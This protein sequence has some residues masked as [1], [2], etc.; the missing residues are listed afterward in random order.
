[1]SAAASS[2]SIPTKSTLSK[3]DDGAV[4][5]DKKVM[6]LLKFPKF[7]KT[8]ARVVSADNQITSYVALLP[9][10]PFYQNSTDSLAGS[11]SISCL[12]PNV[13][14]LD[15]ISTLSSLYDQYRIVKM[16]YL[17]FPQINAN[18]TGPEISSGSI[19]CF[20]FYTVVDYDD[21]NNPASLSVL[22]QYQTCEVHNPWKVIKRTVS[23]CV[24]IVT[25][26]SGI[27]AKRSP[28]LD[29]ATTAV[30]H[31]GLKIG[32]NANANTAAVQQA[33]SI[34]CRVFTQW[35]NIR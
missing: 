21:G 7:N 23:P 16:E 29:A 5:V 10:A 33:F 13:G 20:G 11:Q 6:K 35:R 31:Y 2:S 34:H 32:C 26:S 4:V 3:D 8:G 18:S 9:M 22:R 15:N 12:A 28:W 17:I 1:M 30:N 27:E 14:L 24:N 19:N 25:A